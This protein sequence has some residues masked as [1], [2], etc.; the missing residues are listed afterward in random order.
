MVTL[1]RATGSAP[2]GNDIDIR[3]SY[4]GSRMGS[5]ELPAG[6]DDCLIPAWAC[7]RVA[8]ACRCSIRRWP[9]SASAISNTSP[10]AVHRQHVAAGLGGR[11]RLHRH[12]ADGAGC[13]SCLATSSRPSAA[14]IRPLLRS[15]RRA[16]AAV[17]S[18]MGVELASPSPV[19]EWTGSLCSAGKAQRALIND[20]ARLLQDAGVDRVLPA[21]TAA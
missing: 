18:I 1:S 13:G 21:S 4:Y 20:P 17:I 3:D 19:Y 8:R 10:G 9:I 2:A 12:L 15:A 16:T 7:C 11:V 6:G 5:E 14:T